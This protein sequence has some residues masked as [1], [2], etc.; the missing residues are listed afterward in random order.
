MNRLTPNSVAVLAIALAVMHPAGMVAAAPVSQCSEITVPWINRTNEERAVGIA[1]EESSRSPTGT[2][3]YDGRYITFT[4][5]V[6][7]DAPINPFDRDL[8]PNTTVRVRELFVYDRIEGREIQ[9][10]SDSEQT[11]ESSLWLEDGT[12]LARSRA[13]RVGQTLRGINLDGLRVTNLEAGVPSVIVDTDIDVDIATPAQFEAAQSGAPYQ[14]Q[15]MHVS[16]NQD[17]FIYDESGVGLSTLPG[18]FAFTWA[19]RSDGLVI[20]LDAFVEEQTGVAGLAGFAFVSSV[21]GDGRRIAIQSLAKLT[22]DQTG[23]FYRFGQPLVAGNVFGLVTNAYLLDL[24]ELAVYSVGEPDIS[25]PSIM[26]GVPMCL[27]VDLV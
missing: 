7:P 13:R 14:R 8:N 10:T 12:L 24:D 9:I 16:A 11:F 2:V 21:S 17:V 22:G 20:S 5:L 3:S 23:A 25:V 26:G 18:G 19:R 27:P 6:D 1:F 15:L 4:R